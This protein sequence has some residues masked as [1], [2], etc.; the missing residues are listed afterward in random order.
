M[1]HWIPLTPLEQMERTDYDVIIV[2]TGAGGGAV[3]WRLCEKW[4]KI[5]KRIAVIERGDLL[6]PTHAINLPTLNYERMMRVMENPKFKQP[7]CRNSLNSKVPLDFAQYFAFGGRTLFWGTGSPRLHP[8]DFQFWPFTYQK[9]APYYKIAEQLLS[10]NRYF[11][12]GSLIQQ[13]LLNR[14]RTIGYPEATDF[15]L[16]IDYDFRKDGLNLS[17]VFSSINLFAYALNTGTFDL[18][19][20]ARVVQVLT[21]NGVTKGVKVLT[22]DQKSY[23]IT[24]KV[25]VL[26]A[27]T[28]E[29]P[30]ILLCSGIQNESIG[31]YLVNHSSVG[32]EGRITNNQVQVGNIAILI[33]RTN[34]RR[35]QVEIYTYQP[36]EY[37][38]DS[39]VEI[40]KHLKQGLK[41]YMQSFG[42]V[43]ARYENSVSLS[44]SQVDEYG[45]PKLNVQFTFSEHDLNTIQQMFSSIQHQASELGIVLKK[46]L[47]L[48]PPGSDSHESGT[49]RMGTDPKFSVTNQYGELHQVSN[50]FVADSSVLPYIGGAN[51]VLTISAVAIRTA[52]YIL[53]LLKN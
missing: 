27:S 45:I 6:L 51:P 13:V 36:Y 7:V 19:V 33:P 44:T 31:R 12:K 30:R 17:S 14:L 40:E 10:V 42:V 24:G 46:P 38:G 39:N 18:A 52:D 9:L 53:H 1:D 5:G 3:L 21:D 2:G 20:N 32:I 22:Q 26:S 37:A 28:L 8:S 49:C 25:V 16:A 15:P 4:R 11:T 34:E 48:K 23:V 35:Y 50:L 47:C 43:E 41:I 29:N